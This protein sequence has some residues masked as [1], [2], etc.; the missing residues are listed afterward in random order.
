[1]RAGGCPGSPRGPHR[2]REQR[3]RAAESAL[4][5]RTQAGRRSPH[6]GAAALQTRSRGPRHQAQGTRPWVQDVTQHTV[7]CD[8]LVPEGARHRQHRSPSPRSRRADISKHLALIKLDDLSEAVGQAGGKG[9]QFKLKRKV[10]RRALKGMVCPAHGLCSHRGARAQGEAGGCSPHG[11]PA[12][13]WPVG[14]ETG[15]LEMGLG[16]ST[17]R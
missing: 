5:P 14:M 10:Q 3:G 12:S 16:T 4:A 15:R 1:M 6:H 13:P 11:G 8:P 9:H 7:L 17:A 2:H